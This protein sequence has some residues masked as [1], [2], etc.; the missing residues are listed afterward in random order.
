MFENKA[1]EKNETRGKWAFYFNEL[2][3]LVVRHFQDLSSLKQE[4]K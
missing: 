4:S 1:A 3:P 2:R